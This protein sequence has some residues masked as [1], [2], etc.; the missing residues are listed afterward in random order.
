MEQAATFKAFP[1]IGEKVFGY[2]TN[3]NDF[4]RG[5]S[6]C[7]SWNEI[8]T[9][10]S[11]W[12]KKLKALNR[13]DEDMQKWVNSALEKI[14]FSCANTIV[15]MNLRR[16]YF[17]LKS[18]K[19]VCNTCK[20]GFPTPTILNCH[21]KRH[22]FE[23][24]FRCDTCSVSFRT[25]GHLAK[26]KRSSGH[27]NKVNINATFGQPNNHR[28]FYCADCRLG[29]RIHGHL[30]K[31]LRSKSHILKLENAGKLPIGIYDK[32]EQSGVNFTLIDT[33]SNDSALESLKTFAAAL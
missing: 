25:S 20:R 24:N 19:Y 33:S 1:H 5:L 32:L 3:E 23:R 8:S 16:E 29:F 28:P 30:A 12:L 26:H 11:F 14:D 4:K 7:K 22:L 9:N 15:T 31:H 17:L 27:F 2:L 13:P 21:Q 18:T 10:P 6:V